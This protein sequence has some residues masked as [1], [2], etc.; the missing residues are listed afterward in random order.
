MAKEKEAKQ[1]SSSSIVISAF[2]CLLSYFALY[3]MYL[4]RA[5]IGSTI[6]YFQTLIGVKLDFL[7]IL[8]IPSLIESPMFLAMPAITF[9]LMFFLIDWANDYF[10][11]R[12]ALHPLFPVLF[13][14]LS[15]AAYFV[16]LYWYLKNA[17]DLQGT[18]F[19]FDQMDLWGHLG[20]SAFMLFIW[21]GIFG[22]I[23]RYAVEK[24][25]I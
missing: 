5:S 21:G 16:A 14:L 13:L 2:I 8:T 15:V 3:A 1:L 12:Q 22:W 20:N 7:L 25:K 11:T 24:I 10:E 18:E 19:A 6:G 9:F 4:A 23:A 17:Y